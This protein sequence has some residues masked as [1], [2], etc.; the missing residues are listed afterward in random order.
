LLYLGD[1]QSLVA[2]PD[3][4]LSFGF[5]E[6]IGDYNGD[7]FAD[8]ASYSIDAGGPDGPTFFQSIAGE[9]FYQGVGDTNGDGR[10]DALAMVSSLVGV[11]EAERLYFGTESPCTSTECPNFVP[12]LIPGHQNDGNPLSAILAGGLGDVNGDGFSDFAYVSPG[13][14]AVYLFLGSAAGPASDPALTITAEQGFGF[15]IARL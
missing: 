6:V 7:G 8:L 10:S 4:A 1:G 11:R 14:G 9:F 13:Q 2:R 5:G 3:V 12:L 15:S